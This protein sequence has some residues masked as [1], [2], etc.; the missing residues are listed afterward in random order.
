MKKRKLKP[1]NDRKPKERL[2]T[3]E[4][5]KAVADE[6]GFRTSDILRVLQS[7]GKVVKDGLTDGK[8][9]WVSG[10]GT[11]CPMIRVSRFSPV[12]KC[13]VGG[14]GMTKAQYVP[15]M[16]FHKHIKNELKEIEVSKEALD[17]QY[18]D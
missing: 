7:Y 1:I 12:L 9:V 6:T 14:D 13:K 11:I 15:H 3:S 10:I 2:T 17:S 8:R 4:A 16:T 18:E 5:A